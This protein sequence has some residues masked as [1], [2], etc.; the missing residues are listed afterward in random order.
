[1]NGRCRHASERCG[2]ILCFAGLFFHRI[3]LGPGLILVR[4]RLLLGRLWSR[5]RRVLENLLG[6]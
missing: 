6:L 5:K 3:L 2:G 4:I 1:V